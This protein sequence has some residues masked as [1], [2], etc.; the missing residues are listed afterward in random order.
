MK[1][2]IFSETCLY[3]VK[4]FQLRVI[5]FLKIWTVEENVFFLYEKESLFLYLKTSMH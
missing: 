4:T 3:F 5:L 1:V 2:Y